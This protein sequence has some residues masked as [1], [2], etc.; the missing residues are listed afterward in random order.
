MHDNNQTQ[1][2]Q[3]NK[4]SLVLNKNLI[5]SLGL[6]P[7]VLKEFPFFR[8]IPT[9]GVKPEKKF[10]RHE[11]EY[12]RIK[13]ELINLNPHQKKRLKDIFNV[14]EILINFDNGQIINLDGLNKTENIKKIE[15]LFVHF[16]Q[17][18]PSYEFFCN[19]L[20]DFVSEEDNFVEFGFDGGLLLSCVL[21]NNK[22]NFNYCVIDR[23]SDNEVEFLKTLT[24]DK[25]LHFLDL[26]NLHEIKIN[27]EVLILNSNYLDKEYFP[28]INYLQS[29]TNKY[30]FLNQSESNSF[31]LNKNKQNY[32]KKFLMENPE[33]S[34]YKHIRFCNG[35]T[36]LSKLEE[37]KPKLPNKLQSIW[38]F[39]KFKIKKQIKEK[40]YAPLQV[41]KNRLEVCAV[42]EHRNN[43]QC[44]ICGCY[45]DKIQSGFNFLS[46]GSPGK[47]FYAFEHC[48]IGK[49]LSV[50]DQAIN[51][52]E[53]EINKFFENDLYEE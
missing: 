4:K 6:N 30:V 52:T 45:L 29:I 40:I 28:I 36:I 10:L 35:L 13:K 16:K 38:N 24:K 41:V 46:N 20:S 32:L 17:I 7:D 51:L 34:V 9:I 5:D 27:P 14:D 22:K 48:P 23:H 49:W 1:T 21:K 19:Y 2:Y 8:F 15:D 31:K 3:K 33:W 42:C 18:Y 50:E 47:A 26:I 53:D 44:S 43:N 25:N 12:Q 39:A 11:I 37:H